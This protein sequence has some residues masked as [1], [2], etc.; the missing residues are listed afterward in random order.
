MVMRRRRSTRVD[1]GLGRLMITLRSR[2][3]VWVP[4]P[5]EEGMAFVESI[6][7]ID[8]KVQ[9]WVFL[10]PFLI[11]AVRIEDIVA[12]QFYDKVKPPRPVKG[13]DP[14]NTAP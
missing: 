13:D 1:D 9:T 2:E 14:E 7:K 4:C 6:K 11:A 3:K 10:D 12:V 5:K 8:P